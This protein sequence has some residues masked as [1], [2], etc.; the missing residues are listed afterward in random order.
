MFVRREVRSTWAAAAAAAGVRRPRIPVEKKVES[1]N[2][3]CLKHDFVP[4][5]KRVHDA[6]FVFAQVLYVAD[7][8]WFAGLDWVR[9]RIFASN[10][11]SISLVTGNKNVFS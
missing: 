3:A 6:R 7:V 8:L 11:Q 10:E 1:E 5:P 2:T 9:T 4:T